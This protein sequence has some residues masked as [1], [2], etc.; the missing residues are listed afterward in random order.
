M[1]KTSMLGGLAALLAGL[2]IAHAESP[3]QSTRP[4]APAAASSHIEQGHGDKPADT[5]SSGAPEDATYYKALTALERRLNVLKLELEESQIRAK[6]FDA[7]NSIANDQK[8]IAKAVR[9]TPSPQ[10]AAAPQS[11][12]QKRIAALR[13]QLAE[14]DLIL[15]KTKLEADIATQ[16]DRAATAKSRAAAQ[17][18]DITDLQH[19]LQRAQLELQLAKLNLSPGISS[20]VSR[21]AGGDATLLPSILAITGREGKLTAYLSAPNGST[22]RAAAGT[23]LPNGWTVSAI[24]QNGVTV[25]RRGH[26]QT[27]GFAVAP[28]PAAAESGEKNTVAT[29][30]GEGNRPGTLNAIPIPGQATTAPPNPPNQTPPTPQGGT[31]MPLV[32]RSTY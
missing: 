9:E 3:R 28:E 21:G 2:A 18:A 20:G 5:T 15:N 24:G 23:T 27:L 32:P 6:I 29:R 4:S 30:N 7:Q 8:S 17:G 11:E 19:R 12:Q 26:T 16:S 13:D 31:P 22:Y 14:L 10:N 1:T 25:A